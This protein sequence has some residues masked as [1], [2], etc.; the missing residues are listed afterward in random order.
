MISKSRIN[1]IKFYT[2]GIVKLQK[3]KD[4]E[5]I[6]SYLHRNDTLTNDFHQPVQEARGNGI[7]IFNIQ[8]EKY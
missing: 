2:Y 4:K 3:T 8:K 1:K 6:K 5:E 7:Y